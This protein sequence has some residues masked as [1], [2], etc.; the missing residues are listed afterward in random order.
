MGIPIHARN[1]CE[2]F[3]P[4]SRQC[5]ED[6]GDANRLEWRRM[7]LT[8]SACWQVDNLKAGVCRCSLHLQPVLHP[9]MKMLHQLRSESSV[10]IAS[11][12]CDCSTRRRSE[13]VRC[14][15]HGE[16]TIHRYQ[17]RYGCSRGRVG[18]AS[19]LSCSTQPFVLRAPVRP[20]ADLDQERKVDVAVS[21]F[22]ASADDN[23]LRSDAAKNFT[24]LPSLL[25]LAKFNVDR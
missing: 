22:C 23:A 3:S 2:N 25:R 10:A 13:F 21:L 4:R 20:C 8:S 16:P 11:T 9:A 15:F 7:R 17:Y 5:V 14:S 19:G 18:D 12:R 1:P 6:G 24:A